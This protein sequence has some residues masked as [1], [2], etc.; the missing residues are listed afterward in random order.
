MDVIHNTPKKTFFDQTG[1][2]QIQ[3]KDLNTHWAH[4]KITIHLFMYLQLQNR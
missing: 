3:I 2:N 1:K 4:K